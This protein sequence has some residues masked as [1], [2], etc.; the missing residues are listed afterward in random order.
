MMTPQDPVQI[1]GFALAVFSVIVG[2]AAAF[3]RVFER[4]RWK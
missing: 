3:E 4:D 2:I 1:V